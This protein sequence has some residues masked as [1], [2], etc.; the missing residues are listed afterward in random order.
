[1]HE[2]IPELH[3]DCFVPDCST[4]S[5]Q[6]RMEEGRFNR[7]APTWEDD[8]SLL[9]LICTL[10]S[11]PHPHPPVMN[12]SVPLLAISFQKKISFNTIR[13]FYGRC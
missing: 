1:M 3:T 12:G 10:A 2:M 9:R 4:D 5:S 6:R 7:N 8:V 11:S 13:A